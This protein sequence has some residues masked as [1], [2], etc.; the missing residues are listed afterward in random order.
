MPNTDDL[1]TA[2]QVAA[3]IPV[4]PETVRRWSREGKIPVVRL[5]SGRKRYRRV[6]V[7]ALLAP[8]DGAA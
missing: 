3:L 4:H 2:E 1:M 5:P 6:D 7:E 8:V